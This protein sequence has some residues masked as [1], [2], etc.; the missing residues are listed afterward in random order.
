MSRVVVVGEGEAV[1]RVQPTV[2]G[3]SS[4]VTSANRELVVLDHGE[5]MQG[6][7]GFGKCPFVGLRMQEL[8]DS[9]LRRV[10][11]DPRRFTA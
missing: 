11:I 3:V 1:I 8:H 2:V 10:G 4:L 9:V 5:I 6:S 7:G